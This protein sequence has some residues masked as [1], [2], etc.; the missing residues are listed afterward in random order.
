MV[1]L[2]ELRAA[3]I[4]PFGL[5]MPRDA[6]LVLVASALLDNPGDRRGVNEWRGGPA[7]RSAR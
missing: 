6:R 3:P 5:P 7:S 4:Q 1:I 2:D